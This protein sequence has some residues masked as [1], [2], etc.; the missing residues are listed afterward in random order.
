LLYILDIPAGLLNGVLDD[1]SY[2]SSTFAWGIV[3][4]PIEFFITNAFLLILVIKLFAYLRE[5]YSDSREGK[6]Y[7]YYILVLPAGFIFL[8]I[9]RGLNAGVRSIIFDSSLRYFKSPEIIPGIP[10]LVMHLNLLLLGMVVVILLI[11]FLLILFSF[12][13]RQEAAYFWITF[14]LFQVSGYLFIILQNQPLITP[15]IMAVFISLIFLLYW[16]FRRHR[17]SVYNFVYIAII[18]SVITIS[19]LNYFNQHL[20]RE[21]LKTTAL[22]LNRPNDNLLNFLLRETLRTGA[23]DERTINGY[24][25]KGT[26]YT[27][28]GICFMGRESAAEG[29]AK[30]IYCIAGQKQKSAW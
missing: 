18:A 3:R 28:T 26:N 30:L 23:S 10:E 22:E 6:S 17:N 16:Q 12:I 5:W 1:P 14:L 25:N 2:F 13:R 11:S 29:V 4:S 20:E 8:M 21:S 9:L 7:W 19:L 15:F 24:R 27:G